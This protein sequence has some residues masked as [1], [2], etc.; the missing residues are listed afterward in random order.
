MTTA[1]R[2]TRLAIAAFGMSF[3]LAMLGAAA[4]QLVRAVLP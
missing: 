1:I 3:T 2:L 4:G